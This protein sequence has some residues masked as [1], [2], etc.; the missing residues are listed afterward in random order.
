MNSRKGIGIWLKIGEV[1][2]I[3]LSMPFLSRG[4]YQSL[5]ESQ[6]FIESFFF[7]SQAFIETSGWSNSV[8]LKLFDM[9]V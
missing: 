6:S 4:I 9:T 3:Y 1:T 2:A 5:F 7:Y 8:L